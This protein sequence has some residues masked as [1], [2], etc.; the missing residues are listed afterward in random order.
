MR[1]SLAIAEE[2]IGDEMSVLFKLQLAKKCNVGVG[3][4]YRDSSSAISNLSAS[5]IVSNIFAVDN[6]ALE[7]FVD[8]IFVSTGGTFLLTIFALPYKHRHRPQSTISNKFNY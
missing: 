5:L 7:F 4:K 2:S 3:S 8:N 1:I 6:S